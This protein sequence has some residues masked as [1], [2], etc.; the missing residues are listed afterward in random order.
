MTE[1]HTEAGRA[2][3]ASDLE[4][5]DIVAAAF[6]MFNDTLRGWGLGLRQKTKPARE[7]GEKMA[8]VGYEKF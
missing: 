1:Q 5:H 8:Y 2:K 4:I 6:C 7:R 3:R